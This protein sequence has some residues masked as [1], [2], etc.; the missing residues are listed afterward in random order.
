VL[1]DFDSRTGNL[2]PG[3]HVAPWEEIVTRFGTT[4]HRQRLLEGLRD[5]LLAL[6]S[7]G[8]R[9]VYLDGSFVSTKPEPGDYD[10]C[11]EIDGVDFDVI[12]PVLLTF[13][14]GRATQKAKYLGELF[15]ADTHADPHGTL[16]RDFF[17]TDRDGHP[18]GIVVIEL[19]DFT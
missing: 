4:A 3:E 11:W 1:P 2:P 10:G 9:R 6:K 16:F 19:R 13:D 8:C 18:K 7:V 15:L 14:R 12:D 5:A 17:Q